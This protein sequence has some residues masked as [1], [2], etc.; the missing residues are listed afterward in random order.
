ML[1]ALAVAA[2]VALSGEDISLRATP[3]RT[4]SEGTL[5]TLTAGLGPT[6]R[7]LNTQ[8][9]WFEARTA[10]TLPWRVVA[11][12]AAVPC[13][14]ELTSHTPATVV[15]RATLRDRAAHVI[16]TSRPVTVTWRPT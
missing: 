2:A 8:R 16:R 13:S 9:V 12:C 15:Y 5:V 11:R 6:A 10:A 4:V 7:L 1:A 3:A 14:A